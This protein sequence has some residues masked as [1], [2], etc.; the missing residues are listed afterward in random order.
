[1]IFI[2]WM[3]SFK[4][5]ITSRLSILAPCHT[6]VILSLTFLLNSSAT[7]ST[8]RELHIPFY[9]WTEFSVHGHRIIYLTVFNWWTIR[10]FPLPFFFFF[11]LLLQAMKQWT[12]LINASFRM[13]THTCERNPQ[14]WSCLC[15]FNKYCQNTLYTGCTNLYSFNNLESICSHC[16]FFI[17]EL[18]LFL[19][20][21]GW[22]NT[23]YG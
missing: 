10:L 2:F 21:V 7:T 15:N 20:L 1:M 23:S 18:T 6:A 11:F 16:H 17:A 13:Y 3:L 4:P 22:K 5:T 8:Y 12:I 14:K 9:R 19:I